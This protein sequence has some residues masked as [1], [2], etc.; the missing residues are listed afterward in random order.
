MFAFNPDSSVVSDVVPS[1]NCGQRLNGHVPDMILLHYTGMLDAQAALRRLCSLDS[2]V[3]AHYVVFEDG[4]IIQCVP[5]SERAWHAGLSY[6]AGETDINSCSIGIE[7]ANPGH[8]FG[9][10]DFPSRQVAAVIAL[11]RGIIARR[12]I[13]TDRVLAHSDVAPARKRDPGEKFPWRLLADSG[14][15]LWV[16]PVRIGNGAPRLSAGASGPPV[17]DLQQ[18]LAAFGYGIEVS[19][20]FDAGTHD[21]VAAF[22]RHFRPAQVDGEADESTWKTLAALLEK[23]RGAESTDTAQPAEDPAAR[24]ST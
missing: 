18:D 4:G 7:I 23:R 20:E 12:G 11:C 14:V 22:Q 2:K 1:P 5:E 24:L 19:G 10:P 8:D 13:R 17:H 6:W 3:S 21:T 15:G 9:Y 16:P